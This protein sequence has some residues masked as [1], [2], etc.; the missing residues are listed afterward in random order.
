MSH[1]KYNYVLYG[2]NEHGYGHIRVKKRIQTNFEYYGNNIKFMWMS[3]RIAIYIQLCISWND[4]AHIQCVHSIELV[5][6]SFSRP[7]A[8]NIIHS[9]GQSSQCNISS[10]FDWVFLEVKVHMIFAV[11]C[12]KYINHFRFEFWSSLVDVGETTISISAQR[13]LNLVMDGWWWWA[14]GKKK[15]FLIQLVIHTFDLQIQIK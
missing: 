11:Q 10:R 4:D 12:A 2:R 14:W 13:E 8:H 9:I 15:N 3:A 7:L 5:V 1:I 6:E